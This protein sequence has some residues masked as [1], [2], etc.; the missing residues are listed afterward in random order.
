M[1]PVYS[2]AVKRP[3]T[4]LNACRTLGSEQISSLPTDRAWAPQA[5]TPFSLNWWYIVNPPILRRPG[6]ASLIRCCRLQTRHYKESQSDS[7]QAR[8]CY[9]LNKSHVVSPFGSPATGAQV[10]SS[11]QTDDRPYRG[12][13]QFSAA[14][15]VGNSWRC[16]LA[17]TVTRIIVPSAYLRE[18]SVQDT[19][20]SLNLSF[21]VVSRKHFVRCNRDAKL[22][23]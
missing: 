8:V 22:S 4:G 1:G 16:P 17:I 6:G 9:Q 7:R 3:E 12:I 5:Q 14:W 18:H 23:R 10:S 21:P 2:A 13:H 20:G 19:D 15:S 11:I